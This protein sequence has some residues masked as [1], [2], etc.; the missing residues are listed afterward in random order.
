MDLKVL[1]LKKLNSL[2]DVNQTAFKG[3]SAEI[4][5]YRITAQHAQANVQNHSILVAIYKK[6]EQ[7]SKAGLTVL[8]WKRP[9]S[10]ETKYLLVQDGYKFGP[11]NAAGGFSISW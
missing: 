9:I 1:F 4:T 2:N 10:P 8:N 3:M 5:K 6:I 11:S 7:K